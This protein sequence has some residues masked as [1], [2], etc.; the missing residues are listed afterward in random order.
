MIPVVIGK[1]HDCKVNPAGWESSESWTR[2]SAYCLECASKPGKR[3]FRLAKTMWNQADHDQA[4]ERDSAQHARY[5]ATIKLFPPQ[6][7]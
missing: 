7:G 6:R 1:C 5:L 2:H 3:I 4:H